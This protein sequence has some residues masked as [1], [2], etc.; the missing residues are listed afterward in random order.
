MKT[1]LIAALLGIALPAFADTPPPAGIDVALAQA[2]RENK[3]LVIDFG[4]VWCTSCY[5]MDRH[6]LTGK[7]WNDL[8]QK[9]VF[10]NADVDLPANKPWTDKLK[11]HIFPTY[12][13]IAPDGEE[14]GRILGEQSPEVFYHDMNN[15]LSGDARLSKQKADA[16]KG[17]MKAVADVLQTYQLRNQGKEGLAW[18]DTLPSTVRN[19]SDKDKRV[20][21]EK[22]ELRLAD[23]ENS[24]DLPA[25]RDVAG[26]LL[27]GD[28]GC[29]RAEVTSA[30]VY[31]AKSL[32]EDERKAVA[33]AQK[34]RYDE[35]LATDVLTETP[36]CPA[37]LDGVGAGFGLH[38]LLGEHEAAQA[39]LRKA[40]ALNRE[41]LHGDLKSD[42][43]LA[44]NLS[45]YLWKAKAGAEFDAMH[46]QLI[47]A[48]PNDYV[49]N[50]RYGSR[51]VDDGRLAEGL[52]YLDEAAKKA[53]G[54][55]VFTV[56]AYRVKALRGL[57]R[58][59]DAGKI[60]AQAVAAQGKTYPEL[61][62]RLQ[63]AMKS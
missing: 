59:A 53:F 16:D 56:D 50:F 28:I 45:F 57:H 10:Y 26:R 9:I 27:E 18:F 47:A 35:F 12:L 54:A 31:S 20:A 39:I 52:I 40:I 44:D 2:K 37:Q 23:A 34:K 33:L 38:E 1:S 32:P 4:A 49:Y 13:A 48:Y 22:L 63:D 5:Y 61:A 3:P 19:V 60:V 42:R 41:K 17:S 6:V 11:V 46:K 30:L 25:I 29:E 55:N 14:L 58:D 36:K 62:K 51:L 8:E 43:N 7:P 21:R 24:L 15:L